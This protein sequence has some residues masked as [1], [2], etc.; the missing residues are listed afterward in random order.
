MNLILGWLFVI[1]TFVFVDLIF[2]LESG[3]LLWLG[4]VA[5]TAIYGLAVLRRR[6]TYNRRIK[7]GRNYVD[8]RVR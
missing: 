6:N 7:V 8:T 5:W 3:F 1:G 2:E 4:L